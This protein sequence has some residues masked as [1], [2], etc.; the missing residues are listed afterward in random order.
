MYSCVIDVLQLNAYNAGIMVSDDVTRLPHDY[1]LTMQ[2]DS[3]I[4]EGMERGCFQVLQ[5]EES[6]N[7]RKYLTH[8]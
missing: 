7:R 5:T 3:P 6:A 4:G 1:R 8:N 2:L